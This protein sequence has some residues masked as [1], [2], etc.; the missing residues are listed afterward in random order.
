VN[1]A[2][3]FQ[4]SDVVNR[5][6]KRSSRCN[7]LV[8]LQSGRGTFWNYVWNVGEFVENGDDAAT[9]I[10]DFGEGVSLPAF[11]GGD[12]CLPHPHMGC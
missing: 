5:F 11:V 2:L 6:A 10:C 1:A 9:E 7:E 8:S 12:E 3:E 4:V